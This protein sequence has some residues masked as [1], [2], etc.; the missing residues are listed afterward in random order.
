VLAQEPVF[1]GGVELVDLLVSVRDEKGAL[2]AKLDQ[3]EFRILEDGV[4]QE[5][6]R[7]SRETDLPLTIGMLVDLSGSV[8]TQVQK[9]RSAALTFFEQVLREKDQGF[10]MTFAREAVLVQDVT[11]K[12]QLLS[13]GLGEI[14]APDNRDRPALIR[15]L[16]NT[17]GG[18]METPQDSAA[19]TVFYDALFLAADEVLR[20]ASGR[21]VMIVISDGLDQGS[22]ST[23]Q[24][25]GDAAIRAGAILYGIRVVEGRQGET[26][27]RAK[28]DLEDLARSTGGRVFE[29]DEGDKMKPIF[30]EIEEELR[31]QYSISYAPK[32]GLK[33]GG[34]RSIQVN[35]KRPDYAV[36]TREGYYP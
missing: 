36:Q 18:R 12:L 9:E 6:R 8:A 16:Q 33:G 28:E 7:F 11:N 35:L 5:I 26:L 25:A 32:K 10:V 21:K 1:R 19:S 23:L 29:L 3:S 30:D 2:A 14:R 34:Y 15:R 4:E 24:M 31:S 27:L 20:G 17:R 22:R 13:I